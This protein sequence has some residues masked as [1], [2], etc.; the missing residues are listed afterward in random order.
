MLH[1]FK[2]IIQQA[3]KIGPKKIAVACPDEVSIESCKD[4]ENEGLV[5]PV[6]LGNKKY[7]YKWYSHHCRS[8]H[9]QTPLTSKLSL[10]RPQS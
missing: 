10:K 4:A 5:I 1:S 9:H 6:L 8:S 3:K 7:N 2:E